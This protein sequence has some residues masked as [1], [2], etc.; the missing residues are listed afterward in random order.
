[1]AAWPT[2]ACL[3]RLPQADLRTADCTHDTPCRSHCA[4]PPV[5]RERPTATKLRRPCAACVTAGS[6]RGTA[7]LMAMCHVA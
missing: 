4:Q 5:L 7:K 1:M 2:P 6:R 3:E